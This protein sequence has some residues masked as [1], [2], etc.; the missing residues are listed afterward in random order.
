MFA[1]LEHDPAPAAT[2]PDS[3]A[4]HWDLLIELPDRERL[5]T[6]RLAANPLTS[7]D[8]IDA[9]RIADHRRV[10]LEYEGEISGG[11]GRV[12][13]LDRGSAEVHRCAEHELLVTLSGTHLHGTYEIAR[14]LSQCYLWR[15]VSPP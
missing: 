9:A 15:R 2:P 3:Q 6:W 7:P 5:A 13:R 8:E 12:R 14:G 1:L 4:A 11:R 10:Y